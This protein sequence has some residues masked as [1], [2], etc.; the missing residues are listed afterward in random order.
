MRIGTW[1]LECVVFGERNADRLA[2]LNARDADIWILT[3]THEEIDLKSTHPHHVRSNDRPRSSNSMHWVS[4]WSR[5]PIVSNV[6]AVDAVRSAICIVEAPIG[7]LCLFGTVW[8]W[9]SDQGEYPYDKVSGAWV[10]QPHVVAQQHQ[11]WLRLRESYQGAALCVAGDLNMTFGG[12]GNYGSREGRAACAKAMDQ[13]DLACT[14]AWANVPPGLLEW[15]PIDHVLLPN[16][17]A[18]RTRVVD[19]WRG[20]PGDP[21]RLS[22]HSGIVVEVS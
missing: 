3:E 19:A 16:E 10:R 17:I 6:E 20:K 13:L 2:H 7:Q 12:P 22:D 1:N 21:K 5:F 9:H 11:E 8:P 14:T 18:R 4:I 15:S